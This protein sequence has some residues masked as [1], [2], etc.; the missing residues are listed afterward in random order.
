MGLYVS[1]TGTSVDIP[2]LGISIIHPTTDQDLSSQFDPEDLRNAASLTEAIIAGS[3]AWRKSAGGSSQIPADYDPDFVY[4]ESE[5]TGT[6]LKADRVVTFKD[7]PKAGIL[8]PSD[9]TGS[10]QTATV[11]L[12]AAFP[13]NNYAV[14]VSGTDSRSWS[15]PPL[16]KTETGFV[17]CSNA[18]QTITGNVYWSVEYQFN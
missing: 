14:L 17:V 13:D 16:S 11:V 10:P 5:N 15:V 8:V 3:L 18:N 6:G 1:T 7:M 4:V 12:G 2:E 9:F